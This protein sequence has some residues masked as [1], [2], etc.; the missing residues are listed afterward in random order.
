MTPEREPESVNDTFEAYREAN[1][2]KYTADRLSHYF[3]NELGSAVN[4]LTIACVRL[5]AIEEHT[6][7]STIVKSLELIKNRLVA[8]HS[9]GNLALDELARKEHI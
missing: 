8:V 1:E 5:G 4:L 3:N 9:I 2:G 7:T 6:E